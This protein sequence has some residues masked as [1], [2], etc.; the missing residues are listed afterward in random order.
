V[1]SI[2]GYELEQELARGGAGVVYRGRSPVGETVA[3]KLLLAGRG[4]NEVARRRFVREAQALAK[5]RHPHVVCVRDAGEADGIPYLV[6]DYVTGASLQDR[7]DEAG[8]LEP[9]QATT[10]AHKLA[11]ALAHAHNAGVIHRDVKPSN[12]L[13]DAHGE[14]QLTD[15]GLTRELDPS[16]SQSQLSQT[17]VFLG[18][19]GY[20]PPEQAHGQ[21][22]RVGMHSDVYGLGATL[23]A[24]LTGRPP[25]AAETLTETLRRVDAKPTAPSRQRSGIPAA[26]DAIVLRCL[27]PEPSDR[28]PTAQALERALEGFLSNPPAPPRRSRAPA[29]LALALLGIGAGLG[30]AVLNPGPEPEPTPSPLVAPDPTPPASDLEARLGELW[31][32]VLQMKPWEELEA[33][34]R[35]I[36]REHPD[37]PGAMAGLGALRFEQLRID[38]GT[39]L[40]SAAIRAAYEDPWVRLAAAHVSAKTGKVTA[41]VVTT[42]MVTDQ[43]DSP[44]A[45]WTQLSALYEAKGDQAKALAAAERAVSLAPTRAL[46]WVR[47]ALARDEL[48]SD[49][50]QADLRQALAVDPLSPLAN[51]ALATSLADDPLRSQEALDHWSRVFDR[52]A[53]TAHLYLLSRSE[54]Y[55]S[56]G[57][58]ESA[59]ADLQAL[60]RLAPR[61]EYWIRLGQTH[62][63]GGWRDE[64]GEAF[65]GAVQMAPESGV[66]LAHRA[67]WLREVGRTQEAKQV[68]ARAFAEQPPP[69]LAQFERALLCEDVGDRAGA[70]AHLRECIAAYE[71]GQEVGSISLVR[72]LLTLLE[73][74]ARAHPYTF[75]DTLSLEQTLDRAD[76]WLIDAGDLRMAELG[77][78]RAEALSP[79]HPRATAGMAIVLATSG[80]FA[81][82]E[83]YLTTAEQVA[84]DDPWVRARRCELLAARGRPAQALTELDGV[85]EAHPEHAGAR[86]AR[87]ALRASLG[88][89]AGALTDLGSLSDPEHGTSLHLRAKVLSQAK[90]HD[91]AS[92]AIEQALTHSPDDPL[93]HMLQGRLLSQGGDARAAHDAFTRAI[94]RSPDGSPWGYQARAKAAASLGDWA[95]AGRDARAALTRGAINADAHLLL[96]VSLL[97]ERDFAAARVALSR[98]YQQQPLSGHVRVAY[99][100]AL[101]LSDDPAEGLLH[102]EARRPCWSEVGACW[103][104][105]AWRR[106]RSSCDGSSRAWRTTPDSR[107]R[108]SPCSRP[109]ASASRIGFGCA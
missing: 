79:G 38:E 18:T 59:S 40:Q 2:G 77:F 34:Y 16:L 68:L 104:W 89:V 99:A 84:P 108:P 42:R 22:D 92:R 13:L 74:A 93:L 7:L 96:G 69:P 47:R 82:A 1:K 71:A 39:R 8:P 33:G 17:G 72:P 97:G 11:S 90:R 12:V 58:L 94:Q 65:T 83:R 63:F 81:D 98:A 45:A 107:P 85:V 26:L 37:Q 20:W 78:S 62:E 73:D 101:R 49:Q 30:A 6:L 53:S 51:V 88:D 91:D 14:P 21:L 55:E 28:Y 87:A 95:A 9:R 66:L 86:R 103:A 3:V 105:A 19:P 54:L 29:L 27:E 61:P 32:G 24:L 50:A 75:P 10:L 15:F 57:D 31:W 100:Q 106:W 23:Y 5:L 48:D 70:L 4:S 41:G 102:A 44:A 80:R 25:H 76:Q 56:L 60:I 43:D 46:P 52:P 36:L 35:A 67:S 109:C 64:A